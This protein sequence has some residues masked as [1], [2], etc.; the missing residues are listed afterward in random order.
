MFTPRE[1]A[2]GD[3]VKITVDLQNQEGTFGAGHRFRITEIH[4]HSS[5]KVYDLRDHELHLLGNV[6][7]ED[8]VR[9]E[10]DPY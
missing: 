6:P 1:L 5:G 4:Y 7:E 2:V 8:V 3:H 10:D 9:D